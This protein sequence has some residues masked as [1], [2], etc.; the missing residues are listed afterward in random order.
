LGWI[1]LPVV[2]PY[3]WPKYEAKER[4]GITPDEQQSMLYIRA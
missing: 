4:R 2:A 1:A 3:L